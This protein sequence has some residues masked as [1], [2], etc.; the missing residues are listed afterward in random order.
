MRIGNLS[1]GGTLG[2][3]RQKEAKADLR[4][5]EKKSERQ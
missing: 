1:L 2:R 5:T 4:E 3:T